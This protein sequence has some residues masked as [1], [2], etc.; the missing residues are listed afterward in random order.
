[1]QKDAYNLLALNGG[2]KPFSQSI[3]LCNEQFWNLF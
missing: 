3:Q 1:M 2:K